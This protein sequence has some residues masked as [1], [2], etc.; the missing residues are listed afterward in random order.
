MVRSMVRA[1]VGVRF[2]VRDWVR[3]RVA[4]FRVRVRLGFLLGR[5]G[6]GFKLVKG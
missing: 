5:Q 1:R 6:S 3:V 4:R 2:K